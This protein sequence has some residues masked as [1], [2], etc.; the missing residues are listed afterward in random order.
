MTIGMAIA[1]SSPF[2]GLSPLPLVLTATGGYGIAG[3]GISALVPILYSKAN[4]TSSMPAASALTFV[5]AMGFAGSLLV[6]PTIGC[7]ASATN[8]SVAIGVFAALIP[9]FAFTRDS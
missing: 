2:L 5:S 1:L 6:S 9:A 7:L 4:K 3:F 8:P